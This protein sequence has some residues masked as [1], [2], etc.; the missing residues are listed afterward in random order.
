VKKS[1]KN[2]ICQY[3]KQNPVTLTS[4]FN[5]KIIRNDFSSF[6]D[7]IAKQFYCFSYKNFFPF[8]VQMHMIE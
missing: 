8:T 5:Q 4:N 3:I 1:T 6:G 7:T 2:I